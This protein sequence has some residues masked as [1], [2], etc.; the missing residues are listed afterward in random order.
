MQTSKSDGNSQADDSSGDGMCVRSTEHE[1]GLGYES[2][3]S[4]YF[5][6]L[7]LF[8]AFHKIKWS[9]KETKKIKA[10]LNAAEA[11]LRGWHFELGSQ[12]IGQLTAG[13]NYNWHGQVRDCRQ[14]TSLVDF[15]M[16]NIGKE[17]GKLRQP[18]KKVFKKTQIELDQ[19]ISITQRISKLAYIV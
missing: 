11:Y 14:E 9:Q 5:T 3:A 12:Q 16:R 7:Q 18:L 4:E 1:N 15:E 8:D 13:E 2:S 17:C 19:I 6:H 10:K